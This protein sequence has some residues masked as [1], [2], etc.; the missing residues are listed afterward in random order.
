MFSRI[1]SS[2]SS[3]LELNVAT[4]SGCTD[5]I[6]VAQED[7]RLRSTP[8]HVRFGKTKLLRSREKE[9][10]VTVNDEPTSLRMKLSSAGEAFFEESDEEDE[11]SGR[12]DCIDEQ[13]KNAEKETD[14]AATATEAT[15]YTADVVTQ[16][17]SLTSF[18]ESFSFHPRDDNIGDD[19][20]ADPNVPAGG[21]GLC[22]S[23]EMSCVEFS[24]S[25]HLLS[26]DTADIAT[27][28]DI[29]NQHMLTW[30][31][32]NKSPVLW[33]HPS[34]VCRFDFQ[35]PFY[36]GK[37][38]LPL[39]ASWVAFNRPLT[40][41][42]VKML[43]QTKIHAQSAGQDKTLMTWMFGPAPDEHLERAATGGGC[44]ETSDLSQLTDLHNNGTGF[45]PECPISGA[46]VEDEG[47]AAEVA[48]PTRIK[49][50]L[51]PSAAQ[52]AALHL[53]PGANRVKFSVTS[54]LQ[55]TKMVS[56]FIYLWSRMSKIIVSDVD[57]T[58]TRS[59]VLGQLMPIVGCDWSH[60]GVAELFSK[61]RANRYEL[62]YLTARAIGQADATRDYLFSSRRGDAVCLPEGPLI[63][64][65]D[66]L[67]PSLKREVIDRKPYVFKIAALREVRQLF[68]H[69]YNPFYAGFGNRDTD[70][71]AYVHIG[72]PESRV[73]TVDP[74]GILHHMNSTLKKTYK[75][76]GDI[77]EHMFPPLPSMDDSQANEDQFNDFQYWKIGDEFDVDEEEE[78]DLDP[79]TLLDEHDSLAFSSPFAQQSS[80]HYES[81]CTDRYTA[82]DAPAACTGHQLSPKSTSVIA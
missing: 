58:I 47:V 36:P 25:G 66:R 50:S 40:S 75:S 33:Y 4:L 49:R 12:R 3:A 42:A 38:A 61:C 45:S 26:G 64:S 27:D 10:T 77:S 54:S 29:F 34:L 24:M 30:D 17:P 82:A 60:L 37:V 68:P 52:L 23:A 71:R 7:G 43:M 74:K 8:F 6:V 65:P 70:H 41:N 62:L 48:L 73:F 76:M 20:P 51:R 18:G 44:S 53:K 15:L 81:T 59:D 69:H 32:L 16:N 5:V 31:I 67:F 78:M 39:L 46:V 9:V 19:S 35:P 28:I 13:T 14:D 80:T 21:Q 72:I 1:V 11:A 56:G 63:M 57:G 55:G 79:V 22:S 2:F